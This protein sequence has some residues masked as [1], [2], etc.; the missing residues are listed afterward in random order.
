[1]CIAVV[2]DKERGDW[3]RL[4]GNAMKAGFELW[5]LDSTQI[6]VASQ[7]KQL[8]AMVILCDQ[9]PH[10]IKEHAMVIASDRNIPAYCAECEGAAL[11]CVLAVH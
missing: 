4:Q 3:R 9:V 5:L 6:K 2:G 11:C 1:M 7:I 8:D 10:G